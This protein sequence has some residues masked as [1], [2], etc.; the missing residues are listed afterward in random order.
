MGSLAGLGL[1]RRNFL[2]LA[3]MGW[4][5]TLLSCRVPGFGRGKKRPN[6]LF[7]VVDD[8]RPQLGCYGHKETLSPN[9]DR[10]A[11]RGTLFER[12]YCQVPSAD[13]RGSQCL[14]GFGFPRLS[15]TARA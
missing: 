14:R 5:S 11:A 12:A 7:L 10:L 9:L 6:V 4:L 15:G 3:G 2:G 8:L 1:D 13:L